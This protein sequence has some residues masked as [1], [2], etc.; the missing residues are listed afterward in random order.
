M[1]YTIFGAWPVSLDHGSDYGA[2]SSDTVKLLNYGFNKYDEI[3]QPLA[4]ILKPKYHVNTFGTSITGWIL[5]L[6]YISTSSILSLFSGATITCVCAISG[7][8]FKMFSKNKQKNRVG[9]VLLGFATLMTGMT[10]MSDS[11]SAMQSDPAFISTISAVSHPVPA[12][13][14]GLVFTVRQI[15][16][17]FYRIVTTYRNIISDVF[18]NCNRKIKNIS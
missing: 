10:T 5:C 1:Y 12:F 6:S 17:T 9:T 14:I 3:K 7:I 8:Y 13:L 15:V 11:M 4:T 18:P 2:D 16:I